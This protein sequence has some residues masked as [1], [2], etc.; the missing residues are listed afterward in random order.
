MLY[1]HTP[2]MFTDKFQNILSQ[3]DLN[4]ISACDNAKTIS[5]CHQWKMTM[6]TQTVQLTI[7]VK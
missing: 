5:V 1:I 6:T 4:L 7:V 3:Y 2:H